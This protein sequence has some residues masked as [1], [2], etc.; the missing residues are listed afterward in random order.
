MTHRPGKK[1]R[2]RLLPLLLVILFCAGFFQWSNRSLQIQRFPYASPRLPEGFDGC[3]AVQ[4]SDLHGAV[5]GED[6]QQ[7]IDAVREQE[8]DYIFLTGDLLDQYRRTPHS[9][10]VD[11]GRRLAAIAPTYFVTGNHEWALPDVRGLKRSWR[12]P[13]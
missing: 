7:L 4:L 12:R 13:G 6:N 8:P 3:V 1:R 5:F 10:A 11:L 2:R 9:Y